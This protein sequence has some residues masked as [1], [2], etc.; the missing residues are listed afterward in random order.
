ME[1]CL[2]YPDAGMNSEERNE[3]EEKPSK[4]DDQ[5]AQAYKPLFPHDVDNFGMH[6]PC[7]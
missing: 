2:T 7:T 1:G 5:P 6:C 3:E 4:Q